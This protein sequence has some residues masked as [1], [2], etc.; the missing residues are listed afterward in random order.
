MENRNNMQK[1]HGFVSLGI[2][3]FLIAISSIAGFA[4]SSATTET[5]VAQEQPALTAEVVQNQELIGYD[6]DS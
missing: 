5:S 4:S 1:Q 6:S 3:A 2:G